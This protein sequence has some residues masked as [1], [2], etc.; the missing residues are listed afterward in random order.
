[1]KFTEKVL[2]ISKKIEKSYNIIIT[3]HISP[4]GDAIGSMHRLHYFIKK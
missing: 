3:S 2:T 1:M 4:D